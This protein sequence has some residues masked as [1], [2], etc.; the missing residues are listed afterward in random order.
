MS[1][2]NFNEIINILFNENRIRS[3]RVVKNNTLFVHYTKAD[4]AMNIL[5]KKKIWFRQPAFMN[6][7]NE[8]L[9]GVDCLRDA[10]IKT[11]FDKLLNSLLGEDFN[12]FFDVFEQNVRGMMSDI[13]V[14]CVSEHDPNEDILGRLS[15]WRAYGGDVGVAIVLNNSPLLSEESDGLKT[16]VFPVEYFEKGHAQSYLLD[17]KSK[18]ASININ[19]L[20]HSDKRIF[21]NILMHKFIYSVIGM[22]HIGFREEREWRAVYSPMLWGDSDFMKKEIEVINS[23][24]QTVAKLDLKSSPLDKV[25]LLEP[26]D[27]V[28][29]IIIG[30]TE[31]PDYLKNTFVEL[32][33]KAGVENALEKVVTS[34]IPLR[35]YRG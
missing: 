3:E 25:F 6:D 34:D 7:R 24:P 10:Y 14:F 4:V 1:N 23:I 26:N 21:C 31:Y 18:I 13:Y 27:L 32:L 20:E 5:Q 30:P 9:Y 22:K 8:L 12:D 28:N 11:N 2:Y 15:M 17:I 29:H 16:I 19:K 33:D 35:R